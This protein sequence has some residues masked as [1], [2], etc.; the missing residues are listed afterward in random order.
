[1]NLI[2]MI[3]ARRLIN[4]PEDKL[5]CVSPLKHPWAWEMLDRMENNHWL[6]KSIPMGDDVLCYRTRMDQAER[7]MYDRSLAFLSNLDGIQFNNLITNIGRH[8]TSPEAS[9]TLARQAYE[10]ANHVRSYATMTE[11]VSLAPQE[12]YG[13]YQTDEILA[14]KN[15][16]IMAQ[17]D[18]L[19]GDFTPVKFALA[20]IGNICLEGI[21]FY[22][23]FLNFYVLAKN[24]KMLKSADHIKYIQRDEETH[25]EF[26]CRMYETLQQENPEI[27]TPEFYAAARKLMMA[28]VELEISWGKHTIE[29]GVLGLTDAIVEL[30]IKHLANVRAARLGWEPLYPGVKNPTPWV[31]KFSAV[32]GSEVNFFEGKPT[33]YQAGGL[34]WS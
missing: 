15:K 21:Y 6:P 29:G 33:D 16:F 27:F 18:E 30:R 13:M 19:K 28:A 4:G 25:L 34:E 31:E 3:N 17:S 2:E 26:F 23:G 1:M 11:A 7:Q 10:E 12:I 24:G 5:M 22:S 14:N 20:V 32:N 8:V 9:M